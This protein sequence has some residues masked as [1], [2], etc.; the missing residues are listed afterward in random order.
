MEYECLLP[1]AI[2]L[3]YGTTLI[4]ILQSCIHWEITKFKNEVI[5]SNTRLTRWRSCSSKIWTRKWENTIRK[6]IGFTKSKR[7][8]R[9]YGVLKISCK[10]ICFESFGRCNRTVT[11]SSYHI[12]H[13]VTNNLMAQELK[14][15]CFFQRKITKSQHWML[16]TFSSSAAK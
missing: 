11:E 2:N 13:H 3:S 4:T 6:R 9:F 14:R 1:R 10:L 8:T 15:I 7:K 5:M 12:S 16:R